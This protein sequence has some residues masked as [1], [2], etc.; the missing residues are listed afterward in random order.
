MKEFE[1]IELL[2]RRTCFRVKVAGRLVLKDFELTASQ[3]DILQYL[4]FEGPQRMTQLSEKMG[5]TKST[6]T[7]L[8]SRLESAGY[9][10]KKTYEKDK[11][12]ILVVI[13]KDG[14][15]IIKRVIEKRID[16]ITSSLRD[17]NSSELLKNLRNIYNAVS[18]EFDQLEKR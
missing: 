9:V 17:V 8:V 5:V 4:Y 6:M 10:T 14:E 12:V 1:E 13:T 15:T 18:K 2:L 11:R 7:G 3:F 16:F